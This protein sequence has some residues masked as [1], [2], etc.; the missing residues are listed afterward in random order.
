MNNVMYDEF[1]IREH[2]NLELNEYITVLEE[3]IKTSVKDFD[4]TMLKRI[5]NLEKEIRNILD[6]IVLD[7]SFYSEKNEECLSL[8]LSDI[9]KKIKENVIIVTKKLIIYKTNNQFNF[10]DISSVKNTIIVELVKKYFEKL[11]NNHC[12]E[13]HIFKNIN[14]LYL[15]SWNTIVKKYMI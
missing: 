11:G 15:Q 9:Y 3:I 12:N 7:E 6:N 8:M 1:I 10:C 13:E 2:E 14:K 4:I 5:S